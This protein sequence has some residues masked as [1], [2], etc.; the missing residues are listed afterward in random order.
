VTSV[1]FCF[2]VMAWIIRALLLA[3]IKPLTWLNPAQAHNGPGLTRPSST[4]GPN[5]SY[6]L[7]SSSSSSGG[8]G[9]MQQQQQLPDCAR[10]VS[11]AA[12]SPPRVYG[13]PVTYADAV[14]HGSHV[15]LSNGGGGGTGGDMVG[16]LKSP[17]KGAQG[18]GGGSAA[19]RVRF[20]DDA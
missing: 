7:L 15:T 5:S 12:L 17:R 3:M 4:H 14:T 18:G 9:A 1:F 20:A 19:G 6:S 16:V 8:R 2:G 11:P 10:V 13:T